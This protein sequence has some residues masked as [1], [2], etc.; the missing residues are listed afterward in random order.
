MTRF[1]HSGP[2]NAK[3]PDMDRLNNTADETTLLS[4]QNVTPCALWALAAVKVFMRDYTLVS[5]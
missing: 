3:E 4:D 5:L 2:Y 1:Q